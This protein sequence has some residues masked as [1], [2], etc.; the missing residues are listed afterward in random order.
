M[1]IETSL[2]TAALASATAVSFKQKKLNNSA[3]YRPEKVVVI[4]QAQTG[5][6]PTMNKPILASGNADDIGE[7]FG[8]GS[9]LHRMACKLFPR[10]GNGCKVDTYFMAVAAPGTSAAEVKNATVTA[11]SVSKSFNGYVKVRDLPFEAAADIA[12]KI[13]TRY[14]KNPAQAP[15]GLDL[16]SYETKYIPF[17]LIKGMTALQ[18]AN[19]IVD[20]LLEET[21][22]PF[23][24]SVVT[25]DSTTKIVLTAKWAGADS[26]FE[27]EFVNEDDEAI[28]SADTGISFTVTRATQG[29]GTGTIPDAA[30]DKLDTEFGVTRV[31]SQYGS[32]TV[33]DKLQTK[34]DSF[35]DP[36]IAQFV[37]CYS[38]LEAPESSG[39]PGTYDKEALITLGTARRNDMV[40]VQIYG[41]YGDL[42]RLEYN[43]RNQLLKAGI[44]NLVKKADGSYTLWDLVTFYHPQGQAL[45]LYRY[46]RDITVIANCGY[47]IMNDFRDSEEWKSIILVAEGD[48]TTNPAARTLNDIKAEVN[49]RIGLLGKAGFIA[50]YKKAQKETEIEIDST[51][52]NRVNINPHWDITGVGRIFDIK[53][54]VGF[55]FGG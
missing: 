10:N 25:A 43:E 1:A 35:R 13:A 47:D 12:G 48:I 23:T 2:D 3:V 11:T 26:A 22:L 19:A 53:N 14:Q 32:T 46:D 30:L 45:P 15:R 27:V 21:N 38:S 51:N 24:P 42:R 4:G 7:L 28:T 44:S 9:P 50:D 6:T 37:I 52:P 55:Y 29:A 34:F 40:N 54:F 33:L 36:L 39:V 31:I 20:V 5:K 17:T 49:R 16:N 8:Y 41:D 18:A